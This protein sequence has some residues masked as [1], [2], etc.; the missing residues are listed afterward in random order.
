MKSDLVAAVQ[1]DGHGRLHI[2]PAAQSFPFAYR[3]AMGIAWDPD[4]NSSSTP[5]PREWSYG[6]WFQQVQSM[7]AAQGTRLL[8]GPGTRWLN[9]PASM[10]L[11]VLEAASHAAQYFLRIQ[12]RFATQTHGMYSWTYA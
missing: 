11:E 10:K 5:P 1:I 7:A 2:A 8:L 12:R 9:A 4:R 3:E 6:R